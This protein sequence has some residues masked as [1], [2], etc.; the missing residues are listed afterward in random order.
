MIDNKIISF[1]KIL[2]TVLINIDSYILN[3]TNDK[4]S[5]SLFK[6]HLYNNIIKYTF[7]LL[8][9]G[10]IITIPNN[11]I[12]Q[13]NVKYKK[14]IKIIIDFLKCFVN[15]II[16]EEDIKSN[17]AKSYLISVELKINQI[18][19]RQFCEKYGLEKTYKKEIQKQI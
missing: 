8:Y 5:I 6:K 18:K 9:N 16:D 3:N 13:Q 11:I 10:Y 14:S 4:I 12:E 7:K 17:L 2:S 1:E 15:K 19:L